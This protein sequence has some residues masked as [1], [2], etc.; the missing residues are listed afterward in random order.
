MRLVQRSSIRD[1]RHRGHQLHWRHA[2]FLSHRDGAD[3]NSRPVIQLLQHSTALA[4]QIDTS[5]LT[6]SK[7]ADVFVKF[8]CAEPQSDLD[9][10]NIARLRQNVRNG[11]QPKGFVVANPVTG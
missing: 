2:D 1:G 11:E 3:R 9:R 7:T 10:S 4:R 8:W 5:L 6:E